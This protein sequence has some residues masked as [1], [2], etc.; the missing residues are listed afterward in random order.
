VVFPESPNESHGMEDVRFVRFVE[1]DGSVSYYATYT[2]YDGHEILPQ[3]IE[4]P[5]FLPFRVRTLK[6]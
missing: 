4:T 2:A 6:G 1:D 3:L 5:D